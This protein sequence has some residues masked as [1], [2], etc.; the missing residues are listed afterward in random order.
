MGGEIIAPDPNFCFSLAGVLCL[1]LDSISYFYFGM[2][3]MFGY[4]FFTLTITSLSICKE[5]D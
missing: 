1:S 4:C 5:I 2:I 3:N